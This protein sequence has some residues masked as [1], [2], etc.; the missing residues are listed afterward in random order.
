MSV[1][2]NKVLVVENSAV[3]ARI[4]SE[5]IEDMAR[6]GTILASSM[7]DV[8]RLLDERGDEIFL[9]VCNLSLKGAPDGEAVELLLSQ[10]LPVIVLTSTFDEELRNRYLEKRVLDFFIKG[11]P[12]ELETLVDLVRRV[13]RNRDTAVLVVDDAATVRNMMVRLL[14]NQ[15]YQVHAAVDGEQAMEILGSESDIHMV[16]TDYEM[17]GMDGLE[18]I[19]KIR[20]QYS[21]EELAILGV[22]AHNSGALTAKFL[23][24][25][26]NDFLKKPF[27]AEEFTWRV[28]KNMTELERIQQIR[29]A[30]RRDALTGF[31]TLK[32]FVQ[33]A[34]PEFEFSKVGG[35][36]CSIAGIFLE[37]LPSIHAQQGFEAGDDAVER[38]AS[39]VRMHFPNAGA[40][41]RLGSM[42]YVM[43]HAP[44][45]Q[46][47]QSLNALLVSL[48]GG[49][50]AGAA[51]AGDG[52]KT[53]TEAVRALMDALTRPGRA[54]GSLTML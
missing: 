46:V 44:R 28:N 22:S 50:S 43:A 30:F 47:G 19:R 33:Q 9:A 37:G 15:N 1:V 32:H 27:E 41:G 18:L 7:D 31:L 48:D 51:V 52:C 36:Q 29:D 5:H 40:T 16:I 24:S 6:F 49:L 53:V 38:V 54:K 3:Q 12:G 10:N 25:G 35:E 11:A 26:A 8:E 21:R 13:W 17:P 20:E 45:E 23:K 39:A 4:I 42:I 34:G 2:A 14:E